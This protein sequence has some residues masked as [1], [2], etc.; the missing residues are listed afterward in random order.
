MSEMTLHESAVV[1]DGLVIAR[2]NR[3]TFE[4]MGKGG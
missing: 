3:Q 4:D 2:W 1:F